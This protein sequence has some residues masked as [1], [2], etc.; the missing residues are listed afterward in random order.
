MLRRTAFILLAV[1]FLCH[2]AAAQQFLDP[3]NYLKSTT[4]PG[5]TE[6]VGDWQALGTEVQ[7]QGGI[8]S[9]TLIHNT[10]QD[11]DCCVEILARYETTLPGIQRT[12]P[13]ARFTGTGSSGNYFYLKVQDNGSRAGFDYYFVYYQG[14]GSAFMSGAISPVTTVAR[15]RMQV[16]EE[17]SSVRVQVF[18]DTNM[19]GLWDITKS[20]LTSNGIGATGGVGINGAR[21]ARA[22]D[23]KYFNAILYLNGTPKVGTSV[24]LKGRASI[25]QPYIGACSLGHAGTPLGAG[26]AIPLDLDGLFWASLSNPAVFSN[27]IGLTDMKG[28][29]TMTLNIPAIPQLVGLTVWST[30]VTATIQGIID[31]APDV[32]ITFVS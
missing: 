9:Q 11:L 17:G 18:I 28:D 7:C 27:F 6:H 21:S 19:D 25:N 26:R 3:F 29:F 8:S 15:A 31:I 23:L 16:F 32:Q 2:A 4:I 5:Y 24:T 20:A 12:G 22:D 30:A 1:A 14:G 10:I 13:I